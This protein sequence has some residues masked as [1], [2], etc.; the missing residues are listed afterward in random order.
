MKLYFSILLIILSS[1]VF[2][3]ESCKLTVDEKNG[4]TMAVGVGD[5]SVFADTAFASWFDQ[6]YDTFETDPSL[7]GHVAEKLTKISID[8]VLGT[9]CSDSRREV[10]RFLKITDLL[11]IT[12]GQIRL[13]FV[14]RAKHAGDL[15]ISG[16]D[17]RLVP[18]F[19]ILEDG[20]ELG[21][22]IETPVETL[23]KDF[24]KI[25]QAKE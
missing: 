13:I 16:Y 18:T 22:I 8:I 24:L 12:P 4:K 2:A 11:M 9:W 6:E 19:I 21:R 14:D 3:Q 7:F 1:G 20:K 25:L 17:I 15:D 5:R 23:E 10:P